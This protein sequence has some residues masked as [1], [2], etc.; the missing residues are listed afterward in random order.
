MREAKNVWIRLAVSKERIGNG[1]PRHWRCFIDPDIAE[2]PLRAC[3]LEGAATDRN[4]FTGSDPGR[5]ERGLV[6]WLRFYGDISID[7]EDV[8]VVALLDPRH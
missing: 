5:D 3:R 2:I 6:A 8:A 7:G 4:F 1:D